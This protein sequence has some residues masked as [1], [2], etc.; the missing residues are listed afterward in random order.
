VAPSTF[1]DRFFT[2]GVGR[3]L[4]SPSA[5]LAAGAGAALGVVATVSTGGLAAPLVA[6]LLGGA[7]GYGGRV[8]LAI[9]RRSN[10][11]GIDPFGVNEPWRYAVKD[12][13]AAQARYR[14]ALRGFRDGPLRDSLATIG[15]QIDAAVAEV[16]EVAKQGQQV[17][18]ARK[19]IDDREA[20]WQLDQVAAQI[21]P[22]GQATPTQ[23]RTVE[24]LQAQLAAGAR[25][26]DLM[27][28]TYAELGLINARLDEAVTQ[29]IELSVTNARGGVSPVGDTV[30]QIVDSLN[31]LHQAM[32]GL[33]EPPG[34]QQA[35]P[36]S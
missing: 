8:A 27:R 33:D 15:S 25:M 11:P 5:I 6:G 29:A 26:D 17:A 3:A 20:R 12:A 2:P 28:S 22:G 1:R 7:L 9:P 34:Q 13:L 36:G 32:T 21:P 30:S 16:W 35:A 24:S 18:D 19:R 23:E 31:A 10:G 14:D 4:T